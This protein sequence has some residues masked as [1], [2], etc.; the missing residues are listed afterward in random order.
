MCLIWRPS[1][2]GE[3]GVGADGRGTGHQ[4]KLEGTSGEQLRRAVF[5]ALVAHGAASPQHSAGRPVPPLH[6]GE[7][8][9]HCRG[10]SCTGRASLV[11]VGWAGAS[12]QSVLFLPFY[13]SINRR[14]WL[15]FAYD[16]SGALGGRKCF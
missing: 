13:E 3:A 8:R 11:D 2:W 14:Y 4:L 1:G 15:C 6:Q 9:T 5:Q 16:L 12:K 10:H 7:W